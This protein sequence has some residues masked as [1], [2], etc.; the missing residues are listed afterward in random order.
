MIKGRN[1][2]FRRGNNWEVKEELRNVTIELYK[3]TVQAILSDH[4]NARA[5]TTFWLS[6]YEQYALDLSRNNSLTHV[7]FMDEVNYLVH[8]LD[9][10]ARTLGT[11]DILDHIH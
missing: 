10:L 11:Q 1:T 9:E 2:I 3:D 8:K 7:E 4:W 5:T 6:R